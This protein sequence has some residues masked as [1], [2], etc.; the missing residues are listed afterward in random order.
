MWEISKMENQC[1]AFLYFREYFDIIV[2][3]LLPYLFSQMVILLK[4]WSFV[5]FT[6]FLFLRKPIVDFINRIYEIHFSQGK[7]L[8]QQQGEKEK[9][10]IDLKNLSSSNSNLSKNTASETNQSSSKSKNRKRVSVPSLPSDNVFKK[11]FEVQEKIIHEELAKTPFIKEEVLI[12]ELA[13]YQIALDYERIFKDIFKSQFDALEHIN[14]NEKGVAKKDLLKFYNKA[15]KQYAV[16]YKD[17]SFENWFDFFVIYN[18]IEQKDKL[19]YPTNK[20]QSFTYYILVQRGY[21]VQYK[22]L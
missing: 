15:K 12:R 21:N 3:R 8:V 22:G 14:A 10:G 9:E 16:A 19:I 5:I 4:S 11:M 17:F 2:Q 6:I 1:D 13:S 20:S 18:F 7:I